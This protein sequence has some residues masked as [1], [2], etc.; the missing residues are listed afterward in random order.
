LAG[1]DGSPSRALP[2]NGG[3]SMRTLARAAIGLAAIV[4]LIFLFLRF[5]SC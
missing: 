3:V 4:L 1:S 5:T 2:L